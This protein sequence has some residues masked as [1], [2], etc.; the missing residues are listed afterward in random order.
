MPE[1]AA[2]PVRPAFPL[3]PTQARGA[4]K[5]VFTPMDKGDK[6]TKFT[7]RMV[8]GDQWLGGAG[9]IGPWTSG[10]DF[11][12]VTVRDETRR[13]FQQRNVLREATRR[14]ATGVLGREPRYD[15]VPRTP[16][17]LGEDGSPTAEGAALEKRRRA[18][19][20]AVTAW[21]DRTKP[22]KAMKEALGYALYCRRG[23]VRPYI[24]LGK[25][26][27]LVGASTDPG[28]VS[29]P[30]VTTLDDALSLIEVEAVHPRDG[31]VLTSPR[32]G[33][34]VAVV[35]YTV[36]TVVN[37]A[38]VVSWPRVQWTFL[39][40]DRTTIQVDEDASTEQAVRTRRALGNVVVAPPPAQAT[41]FALGGRVPVIQFTVEP[42]ITPSVLQQQ[43][44][45]N[46]YL[47]ALPRTIADAGWMERIFVNIEPPGTWDYDADGKRIAGSFKPGV[48]RTGPRTANFYQ[49]IPLDVEDQNGIRQT[50]AP[51]QVI[52]R[53]PVDPE[54]AIK[55]V[56]AGYMTILDEV[57]QAHVFL[58]Q[59]GEA[60][61]RRTPRAA[62]SSKRA[63]RW[64]RTC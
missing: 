8:E 10:V 16:I 5:V 18:V 15:F 61:G 63:S 39:L 62:R 6:L 2:V 50:L 21:W 22:H 34:P 36:E 24:H 13:S 29:V 41:T 12:S 45:I 11:L 55:S 4:A 14:H 58:Q 31:A 17:P 59:Q 60:S 28:T 7:D 32:D 53:P 40:P 52:H 33:S 38:Q 30:D 56:R 64:P 48:H 3:T 23:V 49:G 20:D 25:L 42:L 35:Y 43:A 26:A 27:Q 54:F 1:S 47:S 9:W 44:G 37:G 57:H 19:V 51:G 46:F